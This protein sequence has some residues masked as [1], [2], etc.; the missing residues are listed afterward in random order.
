VAFGNL[1]AVALEAAVPARVVVVHDDVTFR[2]PLVSSLKAD[3]HDVMGFADS[4]LAWDALRTARA[5]EILVTRVDFGAG[6]PHGIAL[7]RWARNQRPM[8][9]VLFLAREMFQL[10]AMGLGEFLALPVSI[11]EVAEAVGRL[12]SDG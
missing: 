2:E 5:I 11:P 3:G 1:S 8:V 6:K 10:E 9:R 12:L 4:A 7:A